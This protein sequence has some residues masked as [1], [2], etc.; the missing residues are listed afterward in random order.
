MSGVEVMVLAIHGGYFRRTACA[1]GMHDVRG[2]PSLCDGSGPESFRACRWCG[3]SD[4]PR[5]DWAF[6]SHR[7]DL[8]AGISFVVYR[9]ALA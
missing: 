8:G 4:D 3:G 5:W 2:V 1:L 7:G 9:G 6:T